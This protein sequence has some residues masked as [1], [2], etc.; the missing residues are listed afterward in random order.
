MKK[1]SLKHLDRKQAVIIL[2]YPGAKITSAE[3]YTLQLISRI[4]SGQGSRLWEE[5]REKRGLAYSVGS[6]NIFGVDPGAFVVYA[7]VQPEKV[8]EVKTFLVA[9]MER[10][11]NELV[12]DKELETA[13]AEIIGEKLREEETNAGS[14][15]SAGL[16]EL[17]GLG[18]DAGDRMPGMI[19]RI[20]AEDIRSLALDR[21]QKKNAT[22]VVVAP[23]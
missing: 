9:E 8:Q 1:E 18:Y 19:Q 4:L 13:K 17:Y 15:F 14:A 6:F 16:N 7:S 3:R 10:L 11:R 12:N 5:V 22:I 21:F 2:G 23:Q 20:T